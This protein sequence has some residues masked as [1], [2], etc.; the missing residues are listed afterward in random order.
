MLLLAASNMHLIRPQCHIIHCKLL[1]SILNNSS[2]FKQLYQVIQVFFAYY[3][4][5][6]TAVSSKIMTLYV[7]AGVSLSKS[8]PPQAPPSLWH[9]QGP[10]A[11][12]THRTSPWQQPWNETWN[13]HIPVLVTDKQQ[14]INPT[15]TKEDGGDEPS[16]IIN[17]D[18]SDQTFNQMKTCPRADE[19]G[20][21]MNAGLDP[22]TH[23]DQ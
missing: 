13:Y 23:Q 7:F 2:T 22:P 4:Y 3:I 10:T 19:A 21:T 9:P 16:V 18:W 20:Q 12:H 1:Q 11:C 8:F 6:K 15:Q 14:S 17:Q 5:S